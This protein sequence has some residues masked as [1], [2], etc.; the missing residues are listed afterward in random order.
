MVASSRKQSDRRKQGDPYWSTEE[1]A[2]R[3][4]L[5][6]DRAL[7]RA[8]A[9]ADHVQAW[10]AAE[11]ERIEALHQEKAAAKAARAAAWREQ[12]DAEMAQRKQESLRAREERRLSAHPTDYSHA[13]ARFEEEQAASLNITVAELRAIKEERRAYIKSRG[14]SG[15]VVYSKDH[16]VK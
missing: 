16:K 12:H 1:V 4:S 3:M 5:E 11:T 2:R 8:L 15:Q 9:K 6:Q 14:G 7:A 13:D 10:R